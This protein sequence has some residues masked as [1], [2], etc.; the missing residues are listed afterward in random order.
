MWLLVRIGW[1]KPGMFTVGTFTS[2]NTLMELLLKVADEGKPIMTK[3][4]VVVANE[5]HDLVTVWAGKGAS[6]DPYDRIVEL[7]KEIDE[8]KVQLSE[9]LQKP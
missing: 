4:A 2:L 5:Q 6:A 9:A 3:L 8:L 7:R 1:R